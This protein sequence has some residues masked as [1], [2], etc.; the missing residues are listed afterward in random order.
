MAMTR[1]KWKQATTEELILAEQARNDG[2]EGRARVCAR[3][4]AAYVA[5]EYLLRQGIILHSKSALERIR[6][7]QTSAEISP[8]ERE[9]LEHFLIHTT[10]EHRLPIDADLIADVYLLARQL[11]GE[12]LHIPTTPK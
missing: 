10:P 8:T 7:L 5:D 12:L 1:T 6:Y 4:A 11:L 9:T 2:N 3:R